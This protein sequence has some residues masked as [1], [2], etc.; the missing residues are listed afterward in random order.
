[1][2]VSA[3]FVFDEGGWVVGGCKPQRASVVTSGRVIFRPRE[4]EGG[5][6]SLGETSLSV[7]DQVT[8]I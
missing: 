6:I 2:T 3:G 1:M 8:G 4:S 7:A 5:G